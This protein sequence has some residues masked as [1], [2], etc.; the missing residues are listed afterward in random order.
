MSKNNRTKVIG[1][2]DE[3][4]GD[5]YCLRHG[6]SFM[7]PITESDE[8]YFGKCNICGEIID[9]RDSESSIDN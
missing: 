5:I 8:D 7:F 3:D 4:E 1:Y 6:R 9:P 2:Y